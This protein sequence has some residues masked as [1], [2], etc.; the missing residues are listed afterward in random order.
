VNQKYLGIAVAARYV[1]PL[2]SARIG[3]RNEISSHHDSVFVRWQRTIRWDRVVLEIL[4]ADSVSYFMRD[5]MVYRS[6]VE[7]GIGRTLVVIGRTGCANR[8]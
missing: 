7:A 5:D 8:L 1:I 6:V 2:A 4:E 3:S